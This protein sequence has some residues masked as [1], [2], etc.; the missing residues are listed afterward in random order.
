M[1]HYLYLFYLRVVLCPVRRFWLLFIIG[2]LYGWVIAAFLR[3]LPLTSPLVSALKMAFVALELDPDMQFFMVNSSGT[4]AAD[5]STG[6][7]EPSQESSS[8]VNK[9]EVVEDAETSASSE[10]RSEPNQNTTAQNQKI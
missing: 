7:G 4:H 1:I 2:I 9:P 10:A 8:S 5:L 3:I 6:G